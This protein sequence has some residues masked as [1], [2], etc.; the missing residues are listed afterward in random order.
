MNNKGANHP[1]SNSEIARTTVK[2]TNM[3][4]NSGGTGVVI[5]SNSYESKILT[6]AHVCGVVKFG[7]VVQS[8]GTKGIVT[9]Y[10]VSQLH[11][12]CLITTN[13][14]M[15]ENTE[16]S[17]DSPST[18]S[19]AIVSGHPSLLPVLLTRG[20][21]SQ[22]E[23]I[24]VMTGF[25]HC[26]KEEINDPNLGFLCMFL[27]GLPVLKTYQ[28]QVVS[29][30]IMPGSSGS[31]VWNSSGKIAGLVFAGSGNLSYGYIVPQEYVYNFIQNEVKNLQL[32]LPLSPDFASTLDGQAKIKLKTTCQEGNANV[33]YTLVKDFCKY[34][35]LDAIYEE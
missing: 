18:Y 32:T 29:P 30:T 22:K 10:Q 20:H 31:A 12:L 24:T 16:V 25:R 28:A 17:K 1:I 6:N 4:E 21:F 3:S 8:H 23:I 33:G 7:G 34:V 26:T 15:D 19:E 11:D 35:N 9:Y 2:I 5:S 14:D 13:V 27:G